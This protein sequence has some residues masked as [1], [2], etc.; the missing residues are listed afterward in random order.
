MPKVT[1]TWSPNTK[2]KVMWDTDHAC[3]TFPQEFET[4]EAADAFGKLW[5]YDMRA[6][7]D[8]RDETSDEYEYEVIEVEK[9]NEGEEC[10]DEMGDLRK[11]ALNHRGEP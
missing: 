6:L 7:D 1:T 11:A 4:Y 3:G 8:P 2:F 9:T 5:L 10:W